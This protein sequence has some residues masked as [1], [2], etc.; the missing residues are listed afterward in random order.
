MVAGTIKVSLMDSSWRAAGS[1]AAAAC[2]SGTKSR[3]IIGSDRWTK[4][5]NRGHWAACEVEIPNMYERIKV[6]IIQKINIEGSNR[7]V[8]IFCP[9]KKVDSKTPNIPLLHLSMTELLITK[10]IILEM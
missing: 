9:Y 8:M 4:N 7:E 5:G 10:K 2:S 1:R 6:K 3:L